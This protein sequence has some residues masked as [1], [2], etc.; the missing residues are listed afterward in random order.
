MRIIEEMPISVD[1]SGRFNLINNSDQKSDQYTTNFN[2]RASGSGTKL[3]SAG[4]GKF[5]QID[6]FAHNE[7]LQQSLNKSLE[8]KEK[9]AL[10]EML[11]KEQ[12]NAR[13]EQERENRE[14]QL[15]KVLT[16]Q[17]E[18]A[19]KKAKALEDEK[20]SAA[21]AAK[22]AEKLKIEEQKIKL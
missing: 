1:D 5:A 18:E 14:A 3:A 16:D 12:E 19:E 8:A 10:Q 15:V 13:I 2:L 20:A 22:E 17:K 6:H 11:M 4:R 21:A 7:N 9:K